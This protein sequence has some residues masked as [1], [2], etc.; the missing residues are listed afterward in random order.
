MTYRAPQ[1]QRRL[2]SLAVVALV[3]GCN[4]MASCEKIYQ[5]QLSGDNAATSDPAPTAAA[6]SSGAEAPHP[7]APPD[8]TP[9]LSPMEPSATAV[10]EKSTPEPPTG[11]SGPGYSVIYRTYAPPAAPEVASASRPSASSGPPLAPTAADTPPGAQ[12][13]PNAD[14]VLIEG[15]GADVPP[16]P[17]PEQRAPVNGGSEYQLPPIPPR[18]GL[19]LFRR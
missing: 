15:A 19:P 3:A 9:A 17:P 10:D 14:L 6:V 1:K 7:S 16:R 2:A 18:S 11:S 8:L 4:P 5:E 12:P 13:P